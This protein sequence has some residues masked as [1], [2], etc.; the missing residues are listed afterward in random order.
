M[1]KK[2]YFGETPKSIKHSPGKQQDN[3]SYKEHK[4]FSFPSALELAQYDHVFEG[5]AERI[6]SLIEE[7]QKHRQKFENRTLLVQ[8]IS[9][10]LGQIL[11]VV[12]IA[13]I[14]YLFAKLIESNHSMAAIIML[15]V[16]SATLLSPIYFGKKSNNHHAPNNFRNHRNRR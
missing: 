12:G 11:F 4:D 15:I 14:C 3:K 13:L 10:K 2:K 6:I 1:T 5:A 8:S 16:G 7:E 9:K